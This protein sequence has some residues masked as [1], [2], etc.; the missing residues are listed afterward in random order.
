MR[1]LHTKW[2]AG[3]LCLLAAAC[4]TQ[5]DTS[6]EPIGS[7]NQADLTSSQFCAQGVGKSDAQ[8]CVADTQAPSVVWAQAIAK[9][10]TL[11]IQMWVPYPDPNLDAFVANKQEMDAW[12]ADIKKLTSFISTGNAESYDASLK[13]KLGDLVKQAKTRQ[14]QLIAS[15]PANPAPAIQSFKDALSAQAAKTT[16]P[17]GVAIANDK[18]SIAAVTAIVGD[19]ATTVK[20]FQKP[21]ADMVARFNAYRSTEAGEIASYTKYSQ[22]GASSTLDTMPAVQDE[23]IQLNQTVS[24]PPDQFIVDAMRL[25]ALIAAEAAR[26]QAQLAPY[27]DYLART[28]TRRPDLTSGA[29]RSLDNMVAYVQGRRD[30][31]DA[32]ATQLLDQLSLRRQALIQ[33]ATSQATQATTAQAELLAASGAFLDNATQKTTTLWAAPAKSTKLKLPYLAA[34]YDAFTAFM[35]LQSLCATGVTGTWRESGCNALNQQFPSAQT[36]LQKTIP[37]LIKIGVMLMSGKGPSAATLSD[38]TA[39]LNAGNVKGAAV[40]Y[41]EAVQVSDG[42][43]MP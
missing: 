42:V 6:R 17:V 2:I 36:Y 24:G 9:K 29:T 27:A 1:A 40:A 37:G 20:G 35:Q 5:G 39:K 4:G 25:R 16:G 7:V 13:G 30:R 14:D 11:P 23:I 38:I 34:R 12:F 28:G 26:Y 21:F 31:N 32:L 10:H 8:I 3:A 19:A 22:D 43:V 15:P 18:Q 33:V 41:D